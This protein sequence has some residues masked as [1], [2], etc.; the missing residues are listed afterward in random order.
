M[1]S[2]PRI[3][4]AII[5]ILLLSC[6]TRPQPDTG[7]SVYVTDS[8]KYTL[9]P[10]SAFEED[11]DR[12]QNIVGSFQGNVH[13]FGS[14][15]KSDDTEVAISFFNQLGGN[16]GELLYTGDT[17]KV[18]SHF[19]P[20]GTKFEYMMADFQFCYCQKEL[21]SDRLEETGLR[22]EYSEEDGNEIRQI[23]SQDQLI[24]QVERGKDYTRLRNFLRQYSYDIREKF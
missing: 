16:V 18:N 7:Y 4:T 8:Q 6:A 24:I 1:K 20:Q 14:Y 13:I 2:V 11:M 23:W 5:V 3:L 19:F 10:P 21:L 9:L 12:F 22:L 15:I 17:L